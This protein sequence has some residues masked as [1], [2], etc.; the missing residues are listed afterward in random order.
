MQTRHDTA[1]RDQGIMIGFDGKR[2][3]RFSDGRQ[4][5]R[6]HAGSRL[7]RIIEMPL[8]GNGRQLINDT[9]R[10]IKAFRWISSGCSPQ[11]VT[12]PSIPSQ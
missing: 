12:A 7:S 2:E 1:H 6:R 10:S 3:A 5:L 8:A 9:Y 11:T 4:P